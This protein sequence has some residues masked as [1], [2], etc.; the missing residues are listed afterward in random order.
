MNMATRLRQ[1]AMMI[2][3][4]IIAAFANGTIAA[5]ACINGHPS[6]A[7]EYKMSQAVIS[8]RVLIAKRVPPT[9]DDYF[10]DGTMYLVTVQKSYKGNPAD[11]ITIFSENSSGRFPLQI[12]HEYLLFL[13]HDHGRYQVD[14]CG[15]SDEMAKASDRITE[16]EKIAAGRGIRR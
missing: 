5:A 12:G 10:L 8:A 1:Y 4:A 2:L 14:N 13:Y 11:T 7:S 3:A 16:V 15:S 9:R 6:V